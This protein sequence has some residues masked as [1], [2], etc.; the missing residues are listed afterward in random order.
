[1]Q[2]KKSSIKGGI[3]A[4]GRV[5]ENGRFIIENVPPEDD[6]IVTTIYKGKEYTHL[7]TR[8]RFLHKEVQFARGGKGPENKGSPIKIDLRKRDEEHVIIDIQ[9]LEL[10]DH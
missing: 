2:V 10:S 7:Y 6:L 8:E 4:E 1:M 5:D 9:D 3:V